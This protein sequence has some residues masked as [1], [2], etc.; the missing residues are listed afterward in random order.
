MKKVFQTIVDRGHGNC[1]QAA[2]ASLFDLE[3][4]EVP[5]F[6]EY[7]NWFEPIKKFLGEHDYKFEGMLHN[8]N[9]TMLCTPTNECFHELKWHREFIMTPKRLYR[10]QGINGLF[11][12]SVL[13]PKYFNYTSGFTATHAVLIDR[14]YNIVHDPSPAY[15]K[16]LNYPLAKLLKHNGIITVDLINPVSK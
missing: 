4:E 14:D 10:E 8:K 12:A 16:I 3:L 5:N 1:M 15:Q 9:Y 11:F 2:I 13:S 7:P 6:I